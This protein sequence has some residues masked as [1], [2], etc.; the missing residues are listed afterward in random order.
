[1]HKWCDS[2]IRSTFLRSN[3]PECHV[4]LFSDGDLANAIAPSEFLRI[5]SEP[6]TNSAPHAPNIND[7]N[8]P[9]VWNADFSH[10]IT[11]GLRKVDPHG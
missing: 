5:N 11:E 9:N 7:A 1:M 3:T 6:D 2:A 4:T 8:S 10:P